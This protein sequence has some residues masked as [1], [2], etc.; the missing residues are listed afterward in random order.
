MKSGPDNG[1]HMVWYESRLTSLVCAAV[2]SE[3]TTASDRDVVMLTSIASL[4]EVS[5]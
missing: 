2:A 3:P 5:M 1:W 4:S